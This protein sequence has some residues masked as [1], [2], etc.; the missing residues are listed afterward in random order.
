[1]FGLARV[2]RIYGTYP[3]PDLFFQTTV[4][5]A[6]DTHEFCTFMSLLLAIVAHNLLQTDSSLSS[7]NIS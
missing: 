7:C 5:R 6:D 3:V 1:M 4:K 2:L